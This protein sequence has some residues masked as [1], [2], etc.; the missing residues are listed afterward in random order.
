[1]IR[2][3]FEINYNFV[4]GVSIILLYF[5][6]FLVARLLFVAIPYRNWARNQI[7]I[8][9]DNIHVEENFSDVSPQMR[10]DVMTQVNNLLDRA[11]NILDKEE[12]LIKCKWNWRFLIMWSGSCEVITLS[13]IFEADRHAVRLLSHADISARLN[14][15]KGEI[16]ELPK[17]KQEV[18]RAVLEDAQDKPGQSKENLN[19]FLVDLYSARINELIIQFNLLNKTV[20]LIL[21]GLLLITELVL[22]GNW[23]VLLA[24]A[25][26][27]LLSRLQRMVTSSAVPTDYSAY[28]ASIFLSP[29]VGSLAAWAGLLLVA[30]L[31]GSNVLTHMDINFQIPTHAVLGLAILFGVSERFFDNVMKQVE[32][33]SFSESSRT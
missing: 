9:R 6:I 18:W 29:I 1:M 27:G 33:K 10:T 25:V 12:S 8:M 11:K 19:Q 16:S 28:W 20:W 13:M 22:L 15:A 17:G 24:G 3:A 4:F 31:Q 21:I 26:G 23:L 7:D 2:V 14:R 30:L 5:F 32:T